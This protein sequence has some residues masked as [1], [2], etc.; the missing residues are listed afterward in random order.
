MAILGRT[1]ELCRNLDMLR[2]TILLYILILCVWP[3]DMVWRQSLW[4]FESACRVATAQSRG[5]ISRPMMDHMAH[6]MMMK[7]VAMI[8]QDDRPMM[9]KM[10]R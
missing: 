5:D 9:V 1:I 6:V 8:V 7:M 10:T 3:D 2:S 4:F